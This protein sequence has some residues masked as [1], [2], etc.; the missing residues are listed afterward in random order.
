M[1]QRVKCQIILFQSETIQICIVIQYDDYSIMTHFKLR[2]LYSY[3]NKNGHYKCTLTIYSC[4]ISCI[5]S[6]YIWTPAAWMPNVEDSAWNFHSSIIYL[7][8]LCILVT[9]GRMLNNYHHI[10]G[11]P[12]KDEVIQYL[13]LQLYYNNKMEFYDDVEKVCNISHQHFKPK[14][15]LWR[16]SYNY[17]QLLFV[18][19]YCS[20]LGFKFIEQ[21]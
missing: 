14:D 4:Y 5:I 21:S 18:F 3:T 17:W 10:P 11:Y 19:S 9:L 13:V 2:T 8:C 16:L 6:G 12:Q 1:H 7:G 20:V 15:E